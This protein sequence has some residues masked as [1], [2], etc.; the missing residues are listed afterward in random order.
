M[1]IL[2]SFLPMRRMID[3][4][5]SMAGSIAARFRSPC[6]QPSISLANRTTQI[7]LTTTKVPAR[8]ATERYRKLPVSSPSPDRAKHSPS[9][10]TRSEIHSSTVPCCNWK[11]VSISAL[12]FEINC[13]ILFVQKSAF[14]TKFLALLIRKVPR[15][16]MIS[17]TINMIPNKIPPAINP[18]WP[19]RFRDLQN[20]CSGTTISSA[21]NS[22]KKYGRK[23][24]K[25]TK[26]ET[27][28]NIYKI[29]RW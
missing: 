11:N 10:V 7:K 8:P 20:R 2:P 16:T 22:G 29:T 5:W 9:S 14:C 4:I 21:T 3:R 17:A 18:F 6:C 13:E 23:Y 1:I 12:R 24:F 15:P 27:D 25:A 28:V 19:D 26:T